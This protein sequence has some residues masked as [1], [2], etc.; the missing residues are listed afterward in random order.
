MKT[1][2]FKTVIVMLATLLFVAHLFG[3]QLAG[4]RIDVNGTRY[5]DK[6][7][8]Y[9][10]STSTRGFD[11]GWDA[12]DPDRN[13]ENS[14]APEILGV[15]GTEQY[16]IDVVPDLNDTYIGFQAGEDTTYTM[17]FTN[18]NLQLLYEHLS[19]FDSIANKTIDIY[20]SGTQYTFNAQRTASVVK[21]F[22]LIAT[23]FY[24]EPVTPPVVPTDTTP[25]VVPIDTIPTDT[26]PADTVTTDTIPVDTVAVDTTV[27]DSTS[28]SSQASQTVKALP[29]QMDSHD[30]KVRVYTVNRTVYVNNTDKTSGVLNLYNAQTGKVV[31]N[32][33]YAAQT[34]TSVQFDGPA[35]IYV[36]N[37]TTGKGQISGKLLIQ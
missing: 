20:N 16:H 18:Q 3:Q 5:S 32:F 27:V 15:E 23:K 28:T 1:S 26:I 31:K 35:G 13:N 24:V 37:G 34:T 36:M 7:Y 10:S 9:Q 17:T 29:N 22:K 4:T 14:L 30:M 19:L 6:V 8:I 12:L 25:V 33:R 11:K 2:T 21:R